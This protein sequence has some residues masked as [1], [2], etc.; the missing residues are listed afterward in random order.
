MTPAF[1][2]HKRPYRDTSLLI[3][4]LTLTDGRV[5]IVA[6][7]AKRAKSPLR[8][9]LQSFTPLLVTYTDKGELRSLK[10]AEILNTPYHLRGK[11]L[12]SGFYLN[13]L[14]M[15]LLPRFAHCE[16][17]FNI[18]Q[19]TLEK[20]KHTQP[21]EIALR[22]FE[23]NLLMHLG[24]ALNLQHDAVTNLAIAP[25]KHYHWQHELGFIESKQVNSNDFLGQTL[26]D[27]DK[28]DFQNSE[29][30]KQAKRMMRNIIQN[31]LGS[32]TLASR[33]L[34]CSKESDIMHD[35]MTD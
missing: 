2:L 33:E 26:L 23:K 10:H 1:V 17:I 9:V 8:A 32:K 20:F 16:D 29:T 35:S 12:L 18:Y 6:K 22:I 34:F 31:M 7:G 14:L 3:E 4:L 21:I 13:E 30:L 28:E 27:I 15:Q 19:Q 5:C 24:Y 11:S 25:D